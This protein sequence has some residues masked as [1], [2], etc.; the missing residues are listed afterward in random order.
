[1]AP[2]SLRTLAAV[3]LAAASSVA[4]QPVLIDDFEDGDLS[5][6][7]VFAGGEPGLLGTTATTPDGSAFAVQFE[8]DADQYGGFSGFGQPIDGG[9][10]SVTGFSNPVLEFDLSALGTL[11]LEINFQNTGGGGNGEIRNALRIVGG[12]GVYRRY[13]L[14]LASFFRTN[15]ASFEFDDVAQYVFTVVDAVGDGNPATTETRVLIDNIRVVE[16]QSFDNALSA[17]NFD[18]GDFSAFFFF[19]GGEGI[20]ASST[21]DTPDGSAFAFRG[22]ID[23]DEYNGFAGFGATIAGAPIDVTG[24]RSLNFFLRA[25][26]DAVMEVNIQSDAPAGGNEVRERFRVRNTGGTY[27]RIS[28]PLEAFIQSSASSANLAAVY[29]VVMTFVDV[30]GDGNPATTEFAFEIDAV[31]FGVQLPPVTSETPPT[32]AAPLAL[33]PNPTASTATLRVDLATAS[34]LRV[35]VVDLLGR[36]VATLA[37]GAAPAGSLR[38]DVPALGPGL[39][40]VRVRTETGTATS[41][42]SVVR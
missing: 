16:G 6:A 5:S 32:L 29:N 30:P 3:A 23:G 35:D 12:T 11:T 40:V 34:A 28:L 17:F 1:M 24:Q 22:E 37:D 31:G 39:Y 27:R 20:A 13:A 18:S 26:G 25:N 33:Y 2:L 38:M 9:A 42:L 21:T 10:V 19:A 14:P 4:A 36:V 7:F 8:V 41:R 15:P